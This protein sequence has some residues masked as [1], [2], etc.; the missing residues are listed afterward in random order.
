MLEEKEGGDCSQ[1]CHARVVRSTLSLREEKDG[2]A[3]HGAEQQWSGSKNSARDVRRSDSGHGRAWRCRGSGGGATAAGVGG[4]ALRPGSK[5]AADRQEL[6]R[7]V[8]CQHDFD[9]CG[10]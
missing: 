3:A 6:Q 7:L 5:G 1:V 9:G 2:G 10:I 8:E 4:E